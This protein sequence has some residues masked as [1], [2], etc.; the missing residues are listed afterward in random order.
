MYKKTK[1]YLNGH[2][3]AQLLFYTGQFT[4]EA[5]HAKS[6][7]GP[8]VMVSNPFYILTMLTSTDLMGICKILAPKSK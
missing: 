5:F 8:R 3:H 7:N 2:C 6:T 4:M 1:A